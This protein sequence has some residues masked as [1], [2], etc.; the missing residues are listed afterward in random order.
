LVDDYGFEN[1]ANW[2]DEEGIGIVINKTTN[3]E[4]IISCSCEF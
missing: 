2:I 1:T 4:K 3:H